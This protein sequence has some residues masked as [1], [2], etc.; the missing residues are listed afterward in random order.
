MVSVSVRYLFYQPM[1]EE[2]K[3]WPLPFPAKE[4][5]IWRR[6]CSI[7]QSCCSMMSKRSSDW[8]LESSGAWSFFHQK[9]CITNQTP[10]HLYLFDKSIKS[11][12]DYF[13]SFVVFVLFTRFHFEDIRKSLFSCWRKGE[14]I[15]KREGKGINE[16]VQ[17]NICKLACTVGCPTWEGNFLSSRL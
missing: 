14:H 1:D 2:I 11:L 5:L 9:V 17:K 6:H 4:T 12:Y 7:G 13:C 15:A 10:R 16:K 8:F 3:T